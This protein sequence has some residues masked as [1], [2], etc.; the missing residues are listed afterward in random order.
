VTEANHQKMA[1]ASLRDNQSFLMSAYLLHARFYIRE[2][3]AF[4]NRDANRQKKLR[5]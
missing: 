5:K 4:W 1:Q 3:D 2:F